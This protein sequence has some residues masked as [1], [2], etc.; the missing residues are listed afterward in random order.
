MLYMRLGNGSKAVEMALKEQQAGYREYALA[1][2]YHGLGKPAESNAAME[3]MHQ[4]DEGYAYQ[5]ACAH[6][7]R[8]ENDEAFHWLER[9]HE[10]H[11]SGLIL[12]RMSWMS[13]P[14]HSDPRWRQF[15]EKI[16]MAGARP[17]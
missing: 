6:G 2:I 16:G 9:S 11:D 7:W 13:V 8:G 4:E 12:A 1:I 5:F 3:R 14:L 10:L 17:S 15:L